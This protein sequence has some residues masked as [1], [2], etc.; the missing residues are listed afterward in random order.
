M[1]TRPG[2]IQIEETETSEVLEVGNT[3]YLL[4]VENKRPAHTKSLGEV[5]EVVEHTLLQEERARLET[6]WID[7]L[8]KK[9]F[10]RYF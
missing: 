6:Q 2:T 5:R 1:P 10:V 3:C 9:T 4:L 8:K 7:R